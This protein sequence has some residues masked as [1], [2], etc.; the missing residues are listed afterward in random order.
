MSFYILCIVTYRHE[1]LAISS[2]FGSFV[3]YGCV[4]CYVTSLLKVTLGYLL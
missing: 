1:E 2:V 3:Y 4:V